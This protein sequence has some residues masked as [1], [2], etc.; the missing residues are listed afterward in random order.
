MPPPKKAK[1]RRKKQPTSS[2]A[3]CFVESGKSGNL[4]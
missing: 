1:K 3:D 4:F 2:G